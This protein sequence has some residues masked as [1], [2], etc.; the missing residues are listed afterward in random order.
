MSEVIG[1]T[2]GK[3]E[4]NAGNVKGAAK[5]NFNKAKVSAEKTWDM[6]ANPAERE[7]VINESL[8]GMVNKIQKE[9]Y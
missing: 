4:E 3:V 7:R 9:F 1:S 5:E 6:L 2:A 8:P